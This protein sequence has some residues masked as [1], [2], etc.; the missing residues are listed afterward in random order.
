MEAGSSALPGDLQMKLTNEDV[1]AIVQLLDSTAYDELEVETKEFRLVLRRSPAGGWSRDQRV[2]TNPTLAPRA[3]ADT[4]GELTR[5]GASSDLA[6][7][8]PQDDALTAVRAPLPGTF[9]RAPQPGAPPFVEVGSR[10]A[11][12][13]VVGIIESMKLMNPV[14]AGTSGELISIC[15]HDAEPVEQGAVLMRI[16]PG[17]P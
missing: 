16:R 1:Q 14:P 9:Y 6:S 5:E 15:V 11:A 10:V 8:E 3:Q 17:A 4:A 2:L 12:D 13:T 7:G